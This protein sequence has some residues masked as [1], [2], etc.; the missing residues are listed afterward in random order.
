MTAE[1]TN[2]IEFTTEN[3]KPYEFRKL[4]ATDI[5]T[6]ARLVSKVGVKTFEGIFDINGLVDVNGERSEQDIIEVGAKAI[7][8]IAD[9][10]ID[11]LCACER[12][13]YEVLEKTSNLTLK[14]I[15]ELAPDV[16]VDMIYDFVKKEE[17][18]DFYRAVLRFVN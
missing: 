6:M 9:T 8:G 11:R 3:T 18:P 7:L 15:Q 5:F 2:T 17:L 4:N 12:E 13:I 1:N 10:I 16:F 14:E